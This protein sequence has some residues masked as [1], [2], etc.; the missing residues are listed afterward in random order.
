MEKLVS[1]FFLHFVADF[2]LQSRKMG[3]EKSEKFPVLLQHLSIQF[4][5]FSVFTFNLKFALLNTLV[6][7]IIDWN[8][9]K[10][11]KY[12]VYFRDKTAT[13]ETWKYWEDHIFYTIIGLDQYLHSLT[14]IVLWKL[15]L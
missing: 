9:W 11:Y 7:G 8:I 12:T 10:F 6:H 3:K 13:K 15:F 4:I 5:V 14:L 2:L 1:L